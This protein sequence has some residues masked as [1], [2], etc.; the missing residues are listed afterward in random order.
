[1]DVVERESQVLIADVE[2]QIQRMEEEEIGEIRTVL[3]ASEL[4]ARRLDTLKSFIDRLNIL[5]K[6]Q[7]RKP[8][9]DKLNN[10]AIQL[11]DKYENLKSRNHQVK[12]SV[13][14]KIS[15]SIKQEKKRL[16]HGDKKSIDKR[17]QQCDPQTIQQETNDS[18][19]RVKEMMD[20]SIVTSQSTKTVIEKS[21]K[22]IED[23]YEKSTQLSNVMNKASNALTK[24]WY[25]MG[26]EDRWYYGS[27][28]CFGIVVAFVWLRRIPIIIFFRIIG[29]IFNILI[30]LFSGLINMYQDWRHDKNELQQ[31]IKE[32]IE[33][34]MIGMRDHKMIMTES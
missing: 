21:S 13:M 32:E 9:A 4:A 27:L 10:L 12:V 26:V 20:Q 15:K 8:L 31:R 22:D 7:D 14:M 3:M 28:V 6:E 33:E 23:T 17:R 19:R 5:A 2:E 29:G 18:L 16:I 30:S 34:E 1:M 11:K 24:W 25:S